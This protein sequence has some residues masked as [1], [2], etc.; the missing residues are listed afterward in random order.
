MARI[1]ILE[2]PMEHRGDDTTTPFA[3]VID[4]ASE[5]EA[6]A[7]RACAAESATT[8]GAR[9]ILVSTGTLDIA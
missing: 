3:I 9:G 1:Q 7:L 2:L 6:S 8:L 4:Q 5:E